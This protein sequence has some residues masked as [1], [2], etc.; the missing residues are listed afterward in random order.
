MNTQCLHIIHFKK[1]LFTL[2]IIVLIIFCIIDEGI[3]QGILRE[4][5]K[6]NLQKK[7]QI[8]ST[9]D[10]LD[11]DKVRKDLPFKLGLEL[12]TS[13][14]REH[15]YVS[16]GVIGSA[17]LNLYNQ[18]VFLRTEIGQLYTAYSDNGFYGSAGFN[19]KIFKPGNSRFFLYAGAGFMGLEA[20]LRYVYIMNKN[21]GISASIKYP[22]YSVDRFGEGN[23]LFGIG[24]QFFTE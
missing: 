4:L 22:F 21:L 6:V 7:K 16:I 3:S 12:S 9:I 23:L 10:T 8:S 11:W 15:N 1:N 19:F 18:E 17:D 13:L 5:P 24:V 14:L 20:T 2:S